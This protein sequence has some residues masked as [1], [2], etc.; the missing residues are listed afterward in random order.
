[1]RS[2]SAGSF[3]RE[4][5]QVEELH[6]RN[7]RALRDVTLCDIPGFAVLVGRPGAGKSTL[8]DVLGFLGDAV[9][10]SVTEAISKRGGFDSI[11]SRG[12]VGPVSVSVSYRDKTG[13]VLKYSIK[14]AKTEQSVV[15][16]RE[17]LEHARDE[18]EDMTGGGIKHPSP[19]EVVQTEDS[20]IYQATP[21]QGEYR[22]LKQNGLE[23]TSMAESEHSTPVA[24]ASSELYGLLCSTHLSDIRTDQMRS[25]IPARYSS[26]L[27][28]TGGNL[29][30][31]AYFLQ[32]RHPDTL[33][34]IISDYRF[35][36]ANIS[37]IKTEQTATGNLRMRFREY[38]LKEWFDA[39][40]VSDGML[41]TLAHLVVLNDPR[42]HSLLLV[43]DP[44]RGIDP[45]SIVQVVEDLRS[46][47]S[48]NGQAFIETHSCDF[49]NWAKL[50]EIYYFTKR[51]GFS[52]VRCV[53]ESEL[54]HRLHEN[55][56]L[57]GT[58]WYSGLL[59]GAE[60]YWSE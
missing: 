37:D 29:A 59:E 25:Q 48:M 41:R 30:Q 24:M 8:L 27:S 60:L 5:V 3:G 34:E 18:S 12:Q 21:K 16:V 47:S 2:R 45:W 26:H 40:H 1:M 23:V 9:T 38:S 22:L 6:V 54:L 20:V 10:G 42:P 28:S 15:Q 11:V 14:C 32:H 31:V 53:A 52:T 50:E 33:R 51:K 19:F 49:L 55:G 43:K 39:S 46:Y 35:Q 17:S 36:S 56:D 44:E 58:L 13:R 4:V 7:Y 57:P